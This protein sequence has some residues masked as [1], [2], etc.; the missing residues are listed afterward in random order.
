MKRIMQFFRP[1]AREK[2]L[3]LQAEKLR[4]KAEFLGALAAIRENADTSTDDEMKPLLAKLAVAE[5]ELYRRLDDDSELEAYEQM[6]QETVTVDE[7]WLRLQQERRRR[8]GR[9]ATRAGDS[10]TT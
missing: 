4:A 8:A 10:S 6:L 3:R 1:D 9:D 7:K 2:A 5:R